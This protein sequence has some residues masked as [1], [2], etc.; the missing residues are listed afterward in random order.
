MMKLVI[1]SAMSEIEMSTVSMN[2][3]LEIV[4]CMFMSETAR[5]EDILALLQPFSLK[6]SVIF[7]L[8]LF[9]ALKVRGDSRPGW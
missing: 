8:R 3:I 1:A 4:E 2:G 7:H 6:C 9:A 5:V